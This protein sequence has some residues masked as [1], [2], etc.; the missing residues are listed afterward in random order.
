MKCHTR[1][2]KLS[3]VR[4]LKYYKKSNYTMESISDQMSY[5]KL[6]LESGFHYQYLDCII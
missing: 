4:N 1:Y 6:P 2:L 3:R 5:I